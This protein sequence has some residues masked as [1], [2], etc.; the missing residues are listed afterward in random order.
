MVSADGTVKGLVTR[1]EMRAK[2]LP[3]RST[4]VA[5]IRSNR[6]LVVHQR[7]AW[8]DIWP[9]YWDVAFGGVAGVGESWEEAARRELVEEAG[10][11]G[12][13]LVPIGGPLRYDDDTTRGLSW[14]FLVWSDDEVT[15][16]DGEVERTD[17]VPLE[18]LVEW[19]VDRNVCP[20]S[21]SLIVPI[22]L[23]L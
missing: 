7:A 19:L 16:P 5:V 8:K 11:E 17:E 3:H 21:R 18:G 1:A 12:A 13:D 15:C 14:A 9:G 2:N 6:R 22:L 10:I 20:D 23:A 4:S